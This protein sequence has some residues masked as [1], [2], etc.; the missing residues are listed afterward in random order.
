MLP[1]QQVR[2]LMLFALVSLACTEAKTDPGDPYIDFGGTPLRVR[3]DEP[4][5]TDDL[6]SLFFGAK[7]GR[8][9]C[10]VGATLSV[11]VSPN[12]V[13]SECYCVRLIL[14]DASGT[15]LHDESAIG[16]GRNATFVNAVGYLVRS[17][18]PDAPPDAP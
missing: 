2:L 17:L 9:T 5:T 4:L 12:R 13:V 8:V 11:M 10:P 6:A 14:S 16:I 1:Q 7:D 3:S 18:Q 15:T